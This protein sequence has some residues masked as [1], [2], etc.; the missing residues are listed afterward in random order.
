MLRCTK[1]GEWKPDEEFYRDKNKHNR[2]HRGYYCRL[3]HKASTRQRYAENRE[4]IAEY[5]KQWYAKNRERRAEY[6]K[7][8]YAK[9]RER[10]AEYQKQHYAENRERVLEYKGQRYTENRERIAEQRKSIGSSGLTK[11]REH[12]L[13]HYYRLDPHEYVRMCEQGCHRC[14]VSETSAPHGA[15]EVDHDHS[16][17]EGAKSCGECIRG[18]LC[19][20]C[21]VQ[22]ARIDWAISHGAV[23]PDAYLDRW[24]RE[25]QWWKDQV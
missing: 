16:C 19:R 4:R 22:L 6:Q 7:Q 12:S 2:R 8:W 20:R 15:L 24:E 13:R 9:N 25:G 11:G 10:R 14:G 5:H 18:V 17:C 3:C 23:I 1:C 21:N